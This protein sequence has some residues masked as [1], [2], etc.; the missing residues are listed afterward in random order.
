MSQNARR[1]RL[2]TNRLGTGAQLPALRVELE[3]IEAHPLGHGPSIEHRPSASS[4]GTSDLRYG[5]LS[6]LPQKVVVAL[7]RQT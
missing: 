5:K 7:Q 1:L 4:P 6:G 3:A 2:E